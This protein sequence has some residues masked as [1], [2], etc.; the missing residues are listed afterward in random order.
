MTTIKD[1][2]ELAGVSIST[3]SR[4][5]NGRTY[6]NESTRNMVMEAIR[7]TNYSP[8]A[9]A[10]SLKMGRSD[11]ICLMVPSIENPIFPEITKGVEDFAR[12]SGF[13]VMLC[14]TDEDVTL[15]KSYIDKMKTRQ[16]DGFVVC[17]CMPYSEHIRRLYEEGMPMV[18]VNRFEEKDINKIDTV[19]VDNYQAAFEATQYLIRLGRKRIALMLGREELYLYQE[20]YRGSVFIHI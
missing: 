3:V 2:A 19:S 13:T 7:K 12:R 14:N 1:V 20:R 6:V 8:N 18:L 5:L 11:T 10:K 4:V 16:V 9:L 17:S 15:E